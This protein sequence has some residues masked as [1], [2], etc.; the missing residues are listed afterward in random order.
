[1]TIRSAVRSA[2]VTQAGISLVMLLPRTAPTMVMGSMTR[3]R[4]QSMSGRRATGCRL[5]KHVAAQVPLPNFQTAIMSTHC[6]GEGSP[7]YIAQQIGQRATGD[8]QVGQGDGMLRLKAPHSDVQ[9]HQDTPA[10]DS[11]PCTLLSSPIGRAFAATRQEA[12]S[13]QRCFR[14]F[15]DLMIRWHALTWSMTSIVT[16]FLHR[17]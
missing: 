16:A 10:T 13:W 3:M 2:V 14:S 4:S 17:R 8:G 15:Q 5:Q 11:T 1:M 7:S 12:T 9:R 6:Q